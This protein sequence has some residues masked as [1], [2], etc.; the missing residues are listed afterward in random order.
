MPSFGELFEGLSQKP[1]LLAADVT[2]C[3]LDMDNR[4]LEMS[5]KLDEFV[6]RQDIFTVRETIKNALKLNSCTIDC[7]FEPWCL[8]SAACGDIVGELCAK[9][10]VYNGFFHDAEYEL[11]ED[12]L[13]IKLKYGGFEKLSNTD[14]ERQFD[15][16]V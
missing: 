12:V 14:F 1:V 10:A 11:E 8:T 2:A 6:G 4:T 15:F 9:N 3:N 13:N 7:C 5:L 16:V